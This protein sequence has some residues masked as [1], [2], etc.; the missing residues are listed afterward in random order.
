MCGI[1]CVLVAVLLVTCYVS[2]AWAQSPLAAEMRAFYPRY[3]ERPERLDEIRRGLEEDLKTDPHVES[4]LALAQVCFASGDIRATS[5]DQKVAVYERGRQAA[6]RALEASPENVAAHFWYA[7]NGARLAQT[8]WE[9]R[10]LFLLLTVREEIQI[11]LELNPKY[12]PVYALAG[13]IY[14]ELPG[15]L[16]GDLTKAEAMFRRG[17]EL[18]PRFTE[19]RLGL[20]KSLIKM[21][22]VTE[23]R[24]ELQS[25]LD[26]KEPRY[27][28]DWT[29]KDS[30]QAREVLRS[31]AGN[32]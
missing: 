26:E 18:D 27:L 13:N 29:L 1:P 30:K 22:R 16:G 19:M 15:V 14:Y 20:G 6:K 21:G 8:L 9:I 3:H 23:G 32:P 24:R 7:T 5:R 31:L 10:S 25:V 17:L 28:A 2:G 4:L 11:V 12:T